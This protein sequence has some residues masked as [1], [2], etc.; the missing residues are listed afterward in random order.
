MSATPAPPHEGT[1]P[2]ERLLGVFGDVRGGEGTLVLLLMANVF[3]LLLGYY[4]CKVVREPLVL[5]TG[6]ALGKSAAGAAQALVLMVFI[7]LYSWFASRV[8]RM[9]LITVVLLFFA[10]NLEMFF[11]AAHLRVPLLGAA[12]YVWVGIFNN[13]VVAQFWSYGNDL[14]DEPTGKRLFPVI[15]IGATLGAPFGAKLSAWLFD[16]GVSAY[17]MLHITA[18]VLVLCLALFWLVEAR[19]GER[20]RRGAAGQR[21]APGPNGFVLLARSPYLRLV[22][23]LLLALNFVNTSGQYVLDTLVTAHTSA[24]GALGSFYGNFQFYGSVLTFLL[25][26]FLVSRIVRYLGMA[27]VAL[28]LPILVLGLYGSGVVLTTLGMLYTTKLLENST[29][30]SVMNTARQMFWLVTSREEKYKAKQAA[31]T[32]VVRLG[33]LLSFVFCFAGTVWLGLGPRGLLSGMVGVIVMWLLLA[34]AVVREY[35]RL[36][37]E[38]AA[39]AA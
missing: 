8:D 4:V 27:G 9:R 2:L 22:A 38:R 14:F 29:D 19:Q 31:D 25:Q 15:A 10:L 21:L 26:A 33:D 17:S 7:P 5:A 34:A 1:S 23:L 24:E 36:S 30:Y 16:A 20:R 35:R 28:T 37:A 13:A 12:F 18:A 6:G 39:V 11:F 3:L 32:F